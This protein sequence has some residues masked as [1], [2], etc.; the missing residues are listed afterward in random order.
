MVIIAIVNN[1]NATGMP[2]PWCVSA[3]RLAFFFF[4][5]SFFLC[6]IKHIVWNLWLPVMRRVHEA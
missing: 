2:V 5:F 4:S 3:C 1:N 6:V